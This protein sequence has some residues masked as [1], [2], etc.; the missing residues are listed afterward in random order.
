MENNA[1]DAENISGEC[2]FASGGFAGRDS[3]LTPGMPIATVLLWK[4]SVRGDGNE[5][6]SEDSGHGA[7][8]RTRRNT[9]GA[10]SKKQ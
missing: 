5:V 3:I 1:R 7:S 9:S 2:R 8:E 6:S 4:G 10:V